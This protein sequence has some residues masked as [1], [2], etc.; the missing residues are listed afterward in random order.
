[1]QFQLEKGSKKFNCP[2]C[3]KKTFVR[4]I[5]SSNGEYLNYDFGRCDR[6]SK[7]QYHNKPCIE[8]NTIE[9]YNIPQ[10]IVSKEVFHFDYEV[11]KATIQSERY[12]C[13]V[14][15]QNL[16]KNVL[17]PFK[18]SD[19][20]NVI[21]IYR[22]G[23]IIKGYRSGAVTFP[24]IDFNQNIR[25]VQVKQFDVNNHTIGTDF[26]HS[27]IEKH[28][29]SN[30]K[31][32]PNW[33]GA[34]I[35]QDK[36]ITCLFGEH[37]LSKY[38]NNP[39]ALV[40]APKTAIYGTLYFGSPSDN[41]NNMI[42]LAVYNK[43]SFSFDKLKVLKGRD[44]YVFPDLSNDKQTYNEWQ[45]KALNYEKQLSNTRFIFSDVLER[46]ATEEQKQNGLDLADFLIIQN[47]RIFRN[48]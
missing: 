26:L 12:K 8:R 27:I 39:I 23:T 19:L 31:P 15:V 17:Y 22:L 13:N 2:N 3:G 37:L 46:Y 33:L 38:P 40:E 47:W 30:N 20:N 16:I 36:R 25:A 48:L 41:E 28:F 35:E 42:W 4:Y 6:E 10:P 34:Y 7:C 9:S 1:M 44:V 24:F 43:S 21:S 14:F 29:V 45:E 11:F 5:D 32:L 18:I